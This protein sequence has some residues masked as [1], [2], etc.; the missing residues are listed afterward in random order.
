M[1]SSIETREEQWVSRVVEYSSQYNNDTWSANQVI[2]A[3]K[4][5]PRYGDLNGAWAQGN[6]ANN[7]Y[8]IV[9]F[10]QAVNPEQI[11]IYETYNAGAVV[12][13]S[14][15]NGAFNGEWQTVWE[16]DAPHVE[17]HSRI[18]SVPCV[19]RVFH[20]INQIRLNVN[21]TAAGSWCEIDCIKLIGRASY[22]DI[23]QRELVIDFRQFLKDDCLADVI[24][25]LDDGQTIAA[26]RNILRSRCIYFNQ[27]FDDYPNISDTPIRINNISYDAFYQ[28]LN[29]IYTA[30]I[31]STLLTETCLELMRKADEYYLSPI[32]N[33][34]FNIIEQ[35]L[36]N[37]NVLK[38]YMGANSLNDNQQDDNN[39]I[40]NDVIELCV[41]FV[42]KNRQEVYQSDQMQ[43]L[44]KDLLLQ[45]IQLVL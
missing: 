13:V 15:R 17:T 39:I 7:E 44:P 37:K 32:Y 26:Y 42:K 9:E 18:F 33:Y 19:N 38:I 34:A 43:L 23:A 28:I 40:L 22:Y 2:G 16:V 29:F 6:R 45:L 35:L 10:A 12:K 36:S 1:A 24:F 20:S 21:C 41:N 8:I 11:D 14:V 5:Y 3:P 27:L 4:V 31:D 30:K 25:Q